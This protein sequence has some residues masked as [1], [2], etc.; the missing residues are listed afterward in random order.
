MKQEPNLLLSQEWCNVCNLAAPE[1][2]QDTPQLN[3]Q[4]KQ[5]LRAADN[6]SVLAC[7]PC[8]VVILQVAAS[9]SSCLWPF[10]LCKK[11]FLDTRLKTSFC[12][13]GFHI[14]HLKTLANLSHLIQPCHAF[15]NRE[16][17]KPFHTAFSIIHVELFSNTDN[18]L[19]HCKNVKSYQL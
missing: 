9:G 15:F 10:G 4:L 3:R 12:F 11:L 6:S 18:I 7:Q 8:G 5:D 16:K 2:N 13:Y 14:A 1:D 17:S 19:H